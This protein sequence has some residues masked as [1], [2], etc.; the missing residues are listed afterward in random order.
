MIP[1]HARARG[2]GGGV[3]KEKD[4]EDALLELGVKRGMLFV[5]ELY[6]IFPIEHF[7]LDEMDRFL[8]QLDDL[9][10]KVLEGGEEGVQKVRHK[11]RAA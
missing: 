11:R 1:A 6:D 5:E 9:G 10:V 7:P 2:N 8:M 3:M 4:I